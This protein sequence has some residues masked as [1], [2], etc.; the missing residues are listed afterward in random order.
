MKNELKFKTFYVKGMHCAACETLIENELREIKTIKEALAKLS[1]NK[2][3]IGYSTDKEPITAKQLNKI[4]EESGYA[5]SDVPFAMG[6]GNKEKLITLL[7]TAVTIGIFIYLERAGILM[8]TSLSENSSAPAYFLFGLAAGASS[9]AA[10]VGGVL[11]T[12]STK[13]NE[14]F[15]DKSKVSYTPFVQFNLGRLSAFVLLGGILGIIGGSI[16]ISIELTAY[17]TIIVTLLML[18]VGLTM[19][20]VKFAKKLSIKTPKF[21]LKYLNPKY[22]LQS[23]YIPFIQGALTFFIPCGFTLIAQTNVL[24]TGSFLTGAVLLGAFALG[25]LPM[26]TVISLTS[27]KLGQG[28]RF[29]KYFSLFAGLLIT[30]FALYTLNSQLNV[31]GYPS[32]NDV[33]VSV[34]KITKPETRKVDM[35]MQINGNYQVLQMTAKGLD[36]YPQETVLRANTPTIWLIDNIGALGCAQVVFARGLYDKPINLE[37]GLNQIEIPA[38]KKGV[39]KISCSMG[40]VAPITVTVE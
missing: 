12:L 15:G 34:G 39:Y 6:L 10:L 27:M 13:W 33:L 20:G 32:L 14:T 3:R 8:K 7:I 40:M 11:L 28:N 35:G 38:P 17:L 18:N 9:C 25:T 21:A 1:D 30:F 31:L 5:F 2:V 4:F 23:K 29:S 36:Y 16:G 19:V 26:L 24:T 22:Q 37:A